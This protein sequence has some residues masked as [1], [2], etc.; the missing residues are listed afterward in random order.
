MTRICIFILVLAVGMTACSSKKN[1]KDDVNVVHKAKGLTSIGVDKQIHDFGEITNGEIVA[2]TFKVTN[3][4]KNPLIIKKIEASC[5]C[6]FFNWN[7]KPIPPGD[8]T[9]I[10]VE[11]NSSG[12]Y[13]K[14][15]KV[16]S[17]FANIPEQVKD[18]AVAAYIK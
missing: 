8:S 7:K 17:I 5:G 6:A 15:Y 4:G 2:C 10:E 12:R 13:G 11:F 1:K 9:K 14:Q 3:K 18:V 16:I